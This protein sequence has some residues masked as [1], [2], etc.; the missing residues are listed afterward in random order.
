MTFVGGSAWFL[1]LVQGHEFRVLE[2]TSTGEDAGNGNSDEFHDER[3][4]I[5]DVEGRISDN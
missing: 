4:N 2:R 3:I 1:A 5:L